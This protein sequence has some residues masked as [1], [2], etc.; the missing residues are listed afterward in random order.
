MSWMGWQLRHT[1]HK[2][3]LEM[4]LAVRSKRVNITVFLLEGN[5]F[6]TLRE[7]LIDARKAYE[8]KETT[9]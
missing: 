4:R 9:V 7:S 1:Y 8:L 6:L 2:V 5:I 3:N